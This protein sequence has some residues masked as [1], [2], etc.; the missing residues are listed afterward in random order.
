MKK[1]EKSAGASALEL[2]RRSASRRDIAADSSLTSQRHVTKLPILPDFG[3]ESP[4]SQRMFS[5][6]T[7]RRHWDALEFPC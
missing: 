3:S 7:L 1:R 2:S 5:H 6:L 4:V